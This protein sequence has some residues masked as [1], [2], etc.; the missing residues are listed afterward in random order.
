MSPTSMLQHAD[1]G[2]GSSVVRITIDRTKG[3]RAVGGSGAAIAVGGATGGVVV[4]AVAAA[5]LVLVAM[6]IALV[7]GAGVA[8]TGRRRART[9]ERE[10]RRMLDAVGAGAAPTRLSVDVIRRANRQ[11]NRCGVER[12]TRR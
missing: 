8:F 1:T 7:A 11:G 10:V 9:T 5:P 6:P 3:R 12:L 2:T 4:A